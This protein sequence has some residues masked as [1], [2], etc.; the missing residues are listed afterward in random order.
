MKSAPQMLNLTALTLGAAFMQEAAAQSTVVTPNT[1]TSPGQYMGPNITRVY[2]ADTLTAQYAILDLNEGDL[3]TLEFPTNV[4]DIIFT[5]EGMISARILG[6]KVVVAATAQQ[7]TLPIAIVL[8]DG[9][10]QYFMAKFT[11]G[12][13]NTM[14]SIRVIE[15]PQSGTASTPTGAMQAATPVTPSSMPDER[16]VQASPTLAMPTEAQ[17]AA[18]VASTPPPPAPVLATATPAPVPPPPMSP[19]ALAAPVAPP[20]PVAQV[21][22]AP[23]ASKTPSEAAPAAVTE[24]VTTKATGTTQGQVTHASRTSAQADVPSSRAATSEA[25][26][27]PPAP[28]MTAV[29]APPATPPQAVIAASQPAKVTPTP[30]VVKVAPVAQAAPKP[31]QTS[32]VPP[33]ASPTPP[34]V[35]PATTQVAIQAPP[36][37]LPVK[38]AKPPVT[39]APMAVTPAAA[40][41]PAPQTPARVQAVAPTPAQPTAKASSAPV[42]VSRATQTTRGGSTTYNIV[43]PSVPPAPQG[44]GTVPVTPTPVQAKAPAATP[45]PVVTPVAVA[46]PQSQVKAAA[47]APLETPVATK[48]PSTRPAVSYFGAPVPVTTPPPVAP[49]WTSGPPPGFEEK[50]PA[51]QEVPVQAQPPAVQATPVR[52][53][54]A[55]STTLTGTTIPFPAASGANTLQTSQYANHVDPQL[56]AQFTPQFDGENYVLYYRIRNNSHEAY[57]LDERSLQVTITNQPLRL[58][59]DRVRTLPPGETAY[60]TVQLVD[61]RLKPTSAMTIEW[62]A[63]QTNT[64]FQAVMKVMVSVSR[65]ELPNWQ[66]V[67]QAAVRGGTRP[68]ILAKTRMMQPVE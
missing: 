17:P 13:S 12:T 1:I 8:D 27:T 63:L 23:T 28:P 68:P 43:P 11:K 40:P 10:M 66:A 64:G 31:V 16:P 34:S 59:G 2:Y 14:K 41:T 7:G 50:A 29:S 52:A 30:Q 36:T 58:I 22:P 60:G 51:L 53:A 46:A 38:E 5:K 57:Q 42:T 18:P 24:P 55:P 65:A 9:R 39:P 54:P 35:R 6:S 44:V 49:A 56:V 25:V 37:P 48:A 61:S 33:P 4:T 47:A 20:A 45:A 67:R 32:V 26:I 19:A 21:A 62:P 15:R 3:F